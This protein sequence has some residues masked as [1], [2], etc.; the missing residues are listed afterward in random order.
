MMSGGGEDVQSRLQALS[1][2]KRALLEQRLLEQ[3]IVAAS[4]NAITPRPERSTAPLSYSQE[5]LW[6]L[7]HLF[8]GGVAYNAPAAFRLSG[9]LDGDCL[10]RALE[11]LVERHEILRT[12]YRIVGDQPLQVIADD[13]SVELQRLDLSDRPAEEAEADLQRILYDESQ[14]DLDL[15]NGPVMR[16]T[17]I[18]LGPDDHVL[19]IVLHHIATDG[20]SRAI[21]FND[22]T[23][24]Y[25]SILRG[26]P[27]P[28]P[29]LP[30]QYADYAVWHR[31][32]LDDGV[33]DAQLAY[34]KE[35]LAGA[36]SRLDLPTDFPRP[37]VRS[38]VGDHASLGI[39]TATR[40]GLRAIS[41]SSDGT[42]F[43][44]LV[45]VF[46]MLLKRYSGQDDVVIGTPFAGRNRTELER[47]VGYFINPLALRIDLSGDPTFEE[48]V[49]RTRE[50]TVEAFAHADVPYE[51]IVR[52]TNPERD[53]SQTPVFQAM[54]VLHNPEWLTERPIFQ[55]EGTEASEVRHGKGWSKF[56]VLIG[57]SERATGLNTTWEYSTELFKP[58]TVRQM[59]EHFRT[60]AGSAAQ[61]PDRRLSKLSMLS[62]KERTRLLASSPPAR[63]Q[64]ERE[65][66]KELFEEQV[67]R[68]P[69]ATAIAFEGDRLTYAQLNERANK[70]AWLLRSHGA[71][72]GTFVGVMLEKSLDAVAAVLAV[73]KAG[74]AYV[75]L[76]PNY[77]TDRLEFMLED[78]RPQILL[79][80]EELVAGL[81]ATA[82]TT[83]TVE[84]Q[85]VAGAST[86]DD[87]P[88]VASGD[89][90]AYAIYTSGS[91]GLPKAAMIANRSLASAFFAYEEAY[92]LRELRC[93]AQLASF[94]FDVF[95][96]DIVRALLV[97]AKLVLCPLEV[98]ADPA[99]LYTL[100]VEEG[101]DAVELVPTTATL[102]F[103]YGRR[104][105]KPLDFLRLVSIG[106]EAWR[107]DKYLSF[108]QLCGPRTRLINSYGLTEAT[109]DSAWF[110]PEPDAELTPGRFMPLG[111]AFANTRV[112]VLDPDL[113]PVPTGIPGELCIGGVAVGQG[114]LNRPDL[115]AERFVADPFADEPGAR[116]YRTGDLARRLAD[117]TIEFVGRADRQLKIRGFRVEPGEIEAVLER[118]PG[119][120]AAAVTARQDSS[121]ETRLVAYLVPADDADAPTPD[122]LFEL[123]S[124]HVPVY[125]IPSAWVTL[126]APP[127]TPNGK[128]DVDALP[129]PDWSH[130]PV[131]ERV[132]PRTD[133][134]RAL[135]EIWGR[136]LSVDEVGVTDNFFVL[137]GHSLLAVKLFTQIEARWG[138]K[139]PLATLFRGGT[140][141]QLAATI[142]GE[143]E[144]GMPPTIVPVRPEGSR[145]PLFIVGGIDGEVIHYRA[146]V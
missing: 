136:V 32:W 129:E 122:E 51:M 130:G 95:T 84:S 66:I 117:G 104:E 67:K 14:I 13:A 116:L 71:A 77:P 98:V 74:A 35:K 36:P 53:L 125:M 30:I 141:E 91:T 23:I 96:G 112:Y 65:S 38:F 4:R 133:T 80:R 105:K 128:I 62:E 42:L 135:A 145:P 107:T 144:W 108:K 12:T 41:R 27:S 46:A 18:R 63:S 126:A 115:S 24:L 120:D 11:A 49:G 109:M 7:S 82:A 8:Y 123:A 68:T 55:P 119:I 121:G 138:I 143:R 21:F 15:V 6:L 52:A 56:D 37:P 101:V 102:L 79:T 31:K 43:V 22:L 69:A 58:Q 19:M 78:A 139:L 99:A 86:G 60:L 75:P 10:E 72:P 64:P 100:M 90:T 73:M 34:W 111:R 25:D 50:T 16:P 39:E 26:D 110:E 137:G 146:L 2:S 28:L 76:D 85:A 17:L 114:Y 44:G 113:E 97:G 47:M 134:E 59:M 93:H 88:T 29:P 9:P 33:L 142:E 48:L 83:V 70:L 132:A 54:L 5:L 61:H 140:I 89:D 57:I 40:E 106:G 127:L 94:S 92:R 1:P 3:R 81:P 131:A 45:A 87:P 124:E 118:H 103:D 20:Y